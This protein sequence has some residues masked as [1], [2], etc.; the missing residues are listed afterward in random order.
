MKRLNDMRRGL[1]A[2]ATASGFT[3]IELLIV[4]AIATILMTYG[5]P[6][7]VNFIRDVRASS[8]MN[9]LTSDIH[10]ARNESVKRNAR[11]L[12]CARANATSSS[13]SGAP[14]ATTWMNGWLVCYD[15]DGDSACDAGTADDPNPIKVEGALATPI[16]ISGPAAT[17]VMFPVGSISAGSTFTVTSGTGTTRAAT[18]ASS[19]SVVTT[20]THGSSS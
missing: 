16:S 20:T 9:R 11:V 19:G 3:V 1:A 2:G 18:V 4:L 7:F 15:R 10:L 13:C 12:L 6:S 5:M 14:A 8:V 17:L